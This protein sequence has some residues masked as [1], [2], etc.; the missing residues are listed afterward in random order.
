[1]C[2]QLQASK[3]PYRETLSIAVQV[4]ANISPH[5]PVRHT[6]T[7]TLSA[8]L[9]ICPSAHPKLIVHSRKT[10]IANKK[11]KKVK[12]RAQFPI[13]LELLRLLLRL[14]LRVLRLLRRRKLRR[15]TPIAHYISTHS[16]N[17]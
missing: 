8:H 4:I 12:L 3:K 17:T 6:D 11:K 10:R 16:E 9:P 13:L 5:I 14:L 1:M 15:Y 7:I 2:L